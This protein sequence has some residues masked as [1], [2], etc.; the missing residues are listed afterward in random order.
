MTSMHKREWESIFKFFSFADMFIVNGGFLDLK[1]DEI[2]FERHISFKCD[3]F[4]IITIGSANA[5]NKLKKL[6]DY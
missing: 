6:G 2:D 3:I 5:T 4:L 1:R